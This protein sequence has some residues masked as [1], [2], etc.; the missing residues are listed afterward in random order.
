MQS[1]GVDSL[2]ELIYKTNTRER[3]EN[4]TKSKSKPAECTEVQKQH[5]YSTKSNRIRQ[6][7]CLHFRGNSLFFPHSK[8]RR[9]RYLHRHLQRAVHCPPSIAIDRL[10]R[11]AHF[12]ET[13]P[14]D[15]QRHRHRSHQHHQHRGG[16]QGKCS[17]RFHRR[18]LLL[19]HSV[20]TSSVQRA[21][22]SRPA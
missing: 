7:H 20:T 10:L 1:V 16:S 22:A 21:G 2:N 11:T 17:P 14:S 3:V 18:R 19:L 6:S 9:L 12:R 5:L 13:A 15:P 4:Q 8:H